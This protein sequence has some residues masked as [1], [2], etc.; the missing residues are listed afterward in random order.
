M[1]D[2]YYI[3]I[4]TIYYFLGG[5]EYV[6]DDNDDVGLLNLFGDETEKLYEDNT[7][8][9]QL[10]DKTVVKDNYYKEVSSNKKGNVHKVKKL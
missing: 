7:S 8:Q 3:R 1:S 10:S 9:G 6:F 4:C 5:K 2:W